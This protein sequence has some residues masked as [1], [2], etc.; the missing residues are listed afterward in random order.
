MSVDSGHVLIDTNILLYAHDISAGSKHQI[1]KRLVEDLWQS[2][3]G[4]VSLQ[5][6]QEFY[7]DVTQKIPNPLERNLARQLV[8]ELSQWRSHI[9]DVDDMLRAIDLQP[10]YQLSFWEAM[11]LHSS[12]CLGCKKLYSEDLNHGQ[13]YGNVQV[14]NPFVGKD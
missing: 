9:P 12:A 10:A 2:G 11:V 3:L 14:I 8:A 4:C 13:I 5:I 6:L 7:V 1:S